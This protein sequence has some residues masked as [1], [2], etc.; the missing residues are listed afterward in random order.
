MKNKLIFP[1][2]LLCA[3][4][5]AAAQTTYI[6]LVHGKPAY[7][8]VKQD[9][10]CKPSQI[11]GISEANTAIFAPPIRVASEV[12]LPSEAASAPIA[13]LDLD[14]NDEIAKIWHAHEYGSYDRVPILPPPKPRA[15]VAKPDT[16]HVAPPRS[17]SLKT[18]KPATR[19]VYTNVS[20][21]TISVAYQAPSVPVLSRRDVLNQEI[22]RE[23]TA[24][25]VAKMQLATAQKRNDSANIIKLNNVV[26]DRVANVQALQRELSR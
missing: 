13:N 7:T 16:P 5:I 4:P 21:P 14:A 3:A 9:N 11:N 25:K 1:I 8:T 15:V 24:L 17:G 23:Q 22:E 19:T 2:I 26:R 12:A 18:A 10:S 20:R 6:C